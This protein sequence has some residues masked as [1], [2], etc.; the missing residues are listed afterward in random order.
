MHGH[1]ESAPLIVTL[2]FDP[3]TFERLD[4]LRRR[5]FPPDRNFI[6]AH[7]S[8]FHHLPGDEV[9]FVAQTLAEA[10]RSRGPILLNFP[11]IFKLGRGMAATLA[12]PGLAAVHESLAR[13]FSSWL[14]PQDRQPFRPH[15]TLMNKAEPHD[16]AL[17]FH[18]LSGG[19][20][21]WTG[22]GTDLLLWRYRGGPWDLVELFPFSANSGTKIGE[23]SPIGA[24][25]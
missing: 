2:G 11:K 5:Y 15:V 10:S 6:P 22:Q 12:A 17:A 25:P 24:V 16:A 14:T 3:A 8:M 18:E 13:T 7:V 23:I 9:G 20:E 1:F 19:W 4:A 21:P